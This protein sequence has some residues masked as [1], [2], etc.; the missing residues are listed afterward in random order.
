MVR[1]TFD[2]IIAGEN[3]Q[4]G[5]ERTEDSIYLSFATISRSARPWLRGLGHGVIF[6]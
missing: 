4:T 2:D 6:F 1:Y 3:D 5:E